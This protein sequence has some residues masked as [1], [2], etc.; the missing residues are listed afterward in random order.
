MS[1]KDLPGIFFDSFGPSSTAFDLPI[2][3]SNLRVFIFRLELCLVD[4]T[5][6]VV[7]ACPAS[8]GWFVE[9]GLSAFASFSH[10]FTCATHE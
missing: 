8:L 10:K 2:T 7:A 1:E 9:V 5:V 4:L 3:F 6:D